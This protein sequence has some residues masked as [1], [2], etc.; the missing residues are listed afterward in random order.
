[1]KK[2]LCVVMFIALF[3]FF[4][5]AQGVAPVSN[6]RATGK[7]IGHHA[8]FH[9]PGA[10][11]LCHGKCPFYGGDIDVN[12]PNANAFANANTILVPLTY[13]Y[14]A[15]QLP[16][17]AML[18][19]MLIN[20]LPTVN[21]GTQYDP[22]TGI[23]DVRTG[24]SSGNGGTDVG[25][26]SNTLYEEAT[27]R[28]PFGYTEESV[29]SLFTS[30]IPVSAGTTYWLNYLPQCTNSGNSDCEDDIYYFESNTDGLNNVNGK[31]QP[32]YQAFFE[33]AFFGVNWEN[34]CDYLGSGDTT[35]CQGMSYA[36]AGNK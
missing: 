36:L 20:N 13:T 19:G 18:T 11:A 3:S 30:P 32:S 33:S 24:V 15:L 10:P 23:Y 4:A 26:G 22:A 31:F 6:A 28:S 9:T 34:W 16:V 12:D 8:N 21:G 1:V 7:A 35:E 27:G 14:S 17:N 2:V 29:A 5:L 25:G